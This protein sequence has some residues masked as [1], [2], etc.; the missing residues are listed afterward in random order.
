MITGLIPTKVM[1]G[2]VVAGAL[3]YG[4]G[5]WEG[6]VEQRGYAR[7]EALWVEKEKA[8][9]AAAEKKYAGDLKAALDLTAVLA[10]DIQ[11]REVARTEREK[12][13]AKNVD[14]A[15]ARALAGA[16]RLSIRT[17]PRACPVPGQTDGGVPAAAGPAGPE[18]R[19]DL[20]PETAA[21]FVRLGA[22]AARD[23]RDFN[24]LLDE[25]HKLEDFARTQCGVK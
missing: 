19:A 12:D 13:Y 14:A 4:Y 16:E 6:K 2:V 3:W 22:A 20:V 24:D 21:E 25:Y 11:K 18:E 5:Y 17:A 10:E 15:V 7:A 8:I 9:S 23:V 1:V